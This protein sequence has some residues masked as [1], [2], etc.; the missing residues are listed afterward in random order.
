MTTAILLIDHGS[1][2]ASANATLACVAAAVEARVGDGTIVAMAHMELAEPSIEVAVADCVARGA[3]ELIAMPFMLTAGRHA[4][5]DIPAMVRTAA[6]G[7]GIPFRV[8]AP[9][10]AHDLLADIVLQRCGLAP[11]PAVACTNDADTCRVGTCPHRRLPERT[12][13]KN[14]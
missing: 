6:G 8:V 13:A 3:R 12:A 11:A 14:R 2:R 4:A 10:G 9:I 5:E 7:F 1:R